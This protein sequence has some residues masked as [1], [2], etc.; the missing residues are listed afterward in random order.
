[1]KDKLLKEEKQELKVKAHAPKQEKRSRGRRQESKRG[2][3]EVANAVEIRGS[4]N[5]PKVSDKRDKSK[6]VK[7]IAG[8]E[9]LPLRVRQEEEKKA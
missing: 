7:A 8:R 6:K 2:N 3:S 4:E 1:M 9:Q 5:Q